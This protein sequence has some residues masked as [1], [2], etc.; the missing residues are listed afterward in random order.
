MLD[1]LGAIYAAGRLQISASSVINNPTGGIA[2]SGDLALITS[3]GGASGGIANNG[4]LY[5]QGSLTLIAD[6]G[7]EISNGTAGQDSSAAMIQAGGG[8]SRFT[9]HHRHVRELQPDQHRRGPGYP[10]PGASSTT[11]PSRRRRCGAAWSPLPARIRVFTKA[12]TRPRIAR[13]LPP[14]STYPAATFAIN[15]CS[16]R[17]LLQ[18]GSGDSSMNSPI[19]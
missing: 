17:R 5:A 2:S 9:T 6:N 8:Q 14:S 13:P 18:V 10:G 4:S 7:G 19:S 1:N 3:D 11:S 15:W 12:S 16:R